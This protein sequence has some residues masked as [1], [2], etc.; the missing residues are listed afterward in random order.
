MILTTADQARNFVLFALDSVRSDQWDVMDFA[1]VREMVVGQ[2]Q[3][4]FGSYTFSPSKLDE[5]V[6]DA[7]QAWLDRD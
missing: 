3:M 2:L 4:V 7:V 6:E 5:L 1:E